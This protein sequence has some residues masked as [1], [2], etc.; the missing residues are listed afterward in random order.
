MTVA[1]SFEMRWLIRNDMDEVMAFESELPTLERWSLDR[2]QME[3]RK[4]NG[5][6]TVCQL[7]PDDKISAA[8][9]YDLYEKTIVLKRLIVGRDYRHKGFGTAMLQRVIGKARLSAIRPR[10]D[11]EFFV[12]ETNVPMQLLAQRTG[13]VAVA[14]LRRGT[15][16]GEILFRFSLFEDRM[17]WGV[18]SFC[19]PL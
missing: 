10:Y 5:I 8:M 4:R 1:Q 2:W 17:K 16:G 15:S 11:V 13:F 7:H 12:P 9:C 6:G 3:Q 19:S 14:M 18:T